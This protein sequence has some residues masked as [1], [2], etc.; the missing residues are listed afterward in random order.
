[1]AERSKLIKMHIR[2]FG[3]IGPDGISV[4]LDD[5]VCLV[6]ANN[7][8]KSTVLRA[9]EAAVAQKDLTPEDINCSSNE[10]AVSVELWVHIPAGA[11]NIDEKWKE[12]KD[13]LLL[14]RSRWE[15]PATGGKAIRSTWDPTVNDYAADGKAS[16]LDNVFNSRLPK[17]F[18][19]GSLEDP[20]SEHQ[21]LLSLVIEPVVTRLNALMRDD[22][23]ELRKRIA[24][25]EIE[26]KKPVA[27]FQKEIEEIESKVNNAY[28]QVFSSAAVKLSVDLGSVA[29]DP[30]K[31]LLAQSRIDIDEPHGRTRWNQQGTG[32][33]RALFWS[34]LEV[35]SELNR[36]AEEKKLRQKNLADK[37][38]ELDKAEKKI[39]GLKKEDAIRTCQDNIEVL[40]QEIARLESGE[41][42]HDVPEEDVFLPGYMLLIDEPE[43]AL[44]PAAVRTAKEHLYAL[45][46]DDGWQVMLSTHSPAFVDPLKNHTTIVRLRRPEKHL[47]PNTY[48]ADAMVFSGEDRDNLKCLLAFDLALAEMFF[49]TRVIIVEGDTEY[50]SF[51]EIMNLD[52]SAYPLFDRPVM[53]RARGKATI[54]LIITMLTHFKI[55]FA[56]LHDIDA[57]K[58]ADG[59][60]RNG[61][62]KSNAD[63]A[64]AV[65][66]ARANG[67]RVVHCCS[68]PNFEIHHGMTLPP[69]DKPFE[70][71]R[72]VRDNADI[73]ASVRNVLDV[74]LSGA[75][76]NGAAI[77]PD[78]SNYEA[79]LRAWASEHA[80]DDPAYIFDSADDDQ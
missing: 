72:R 56:V 5:I 78:G 61:A 9:Y 20:A 12:R 33:Q 26:A 48:R 77:A 7:T 36:L 19:I 21:K 57:P 60:R 46:A 15:W 63:I 35:R 3:C 49:S 6:G 54:R 41:Q 37:R 58:T 59:A 45:A 71:W 51:S 70:S 43:T 79:V 75:P 74:L 8:G 62:Y 50:A 52:S 4:A 32:S 25:L 1:M 73:R 11:G 69:K 29:Y 10:G 42:G 38:K 76:G 39:G 65:A 2:N 67:Q 66:A 34:I 30:Q 53:V 40:K 24:D 28:R 44:H 14:V 16:G 55:D 80:V 68:C 13:G 22:T 18:R 23:S 64:A 27:E 17:P 31:S 47:P